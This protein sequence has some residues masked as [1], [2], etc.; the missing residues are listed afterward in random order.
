[1]LCEV[2]Q[3]S[4]HSHIHHIHPLLSVEYHPLPP[5]ADPSTSK[6]MLNGL[7]GRRQDRRDDRRD[8]RQDRQDRRHDYISSLNTLC[9]L[10]RFQ[11][12]YLPRNIGLSIYS[13]DQSRPYK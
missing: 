2:E 8:R 13:A 9:W 1:M 3:P 12:L 6:T 7:R 11:L 5:Q 4:S 10:R